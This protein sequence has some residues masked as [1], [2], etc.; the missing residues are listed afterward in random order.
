MKLYIKKFINLLC[1]SLFVIFLFLT[2]YITLSYLKNDNIY[3][4]FNQIL[5]QDTPFA[6][7]V[8]FFS[9]TWSG[10]NNIIGIYIS[11]FLSTFFCYGFV[12]G[13]FFILTWLILRIMLLITTWG[14]KINV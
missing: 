5:E 8:Y 9:N 7:L 6:K 3:W 4:E 2:I 12:L 14:G 10:S 11:I 1:F 13:L